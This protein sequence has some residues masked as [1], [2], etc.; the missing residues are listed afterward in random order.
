MA[1]L[2][3]P[4]IDED[5]AEWRQMA[6]VEGVE[7]RPV[8]AVTPY[9]GPLKSFGTDAYTYYYRLREGDKPSEGERVDPNYTGRVIVDVPATLPQE[10]FAPRTQSIEEIQR[11]YRIVGKR[12]TMVKVKATKA[13]KAKASACC[14]HCGGKL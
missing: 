9:S 2:V 6:N 8:D 4:E 14:P 12:V 1:T 5:E 7:L 10:M 11:R 13:V 3:A